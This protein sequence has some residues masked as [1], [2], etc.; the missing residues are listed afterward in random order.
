MKKLQIN[1]IEIDENRLEELKRI[2]KDNNK[3]KA[4]KDDFKNNNFN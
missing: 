2:N 1:I 3:F 4:C